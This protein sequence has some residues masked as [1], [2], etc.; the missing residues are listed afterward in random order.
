MST[1]HNN[2]FSLSLLRN[3]V[4][5]VGSGKSATDIKSW[6]L[7]GW[8]LLTINHAHSIRPDW[9]FAGYSPDMPKDRRPIKS[10]NH[11]YLF[12]AMSGPIATFESLS[13]NDQRSYNNALSRWNRPI[14]TMFF[15]ASYWALIHLKP[16]IIGYMGCD[17]NYTIQNDA[18]HFYGMGLDTGND[19]QPDPLKYFENKQMS[20]G[21]CLADL[22][23]DAE[24][25][26]CTLVNFSTEETKLPY[27]KLR[28]MNQ[29]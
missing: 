27:A 5:I 15:A 20:L 29:S 28:W 9:E 11:Q 8:S 25:V 13:A 23:I 4:L 19:K 18:T 6:D 22:A 7:A 12:S 14:D 26:G 21:S 1:K 16:S 17:M 2:E 10:S 24:S 3:K